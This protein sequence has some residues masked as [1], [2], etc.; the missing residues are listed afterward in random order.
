MAAGK[1]VVASRIEGIDESVEDG[2]SGLLVTPGDAA[3]LA[4]AINQIAAD[5]E[6]AAVMGQHGRT[7]VL[8]RFS[9]TEMIKAHA[10][11]YAELCQI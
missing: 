5:P 7:A 1:P 3:G 8:E 6:A 11:L 9:E 10:K 2:V 4:A